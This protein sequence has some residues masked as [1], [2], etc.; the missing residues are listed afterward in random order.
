MVSIFSSLHFRRYLCVCL[1]SSTWLYACF[2]LLFR[3]SRISSIRSKRSYSSA[4]T[5][6]L[7][8]PLRV[9]RA[10]L[11]GNSTWSEMTAFCFEK[12]VMYTTFSLKCECFSSFWILITLLW[13]SNWQLNRFGRT[14]SNEANTLNTESAGPCFTW[15]LTT[16]G[17]SRS[18]TTSFVYTK[19]F[20]R[21][22]TSVSY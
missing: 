18:F 14:E 4:F 1:F 2:C 16:T 15:M 21:I 22:S 20:F 6:V 5:S 9:L 10:A 8:L 12:I 11:L 3:F 7:A 17:D 13:N 19:L